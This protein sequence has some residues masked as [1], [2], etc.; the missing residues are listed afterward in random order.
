VAGVEETARERGALAEAGIGGARASTRQRLA[1]EWHGDT[2]VAFV[3]LGM[4]KLGG[5]ELNY[6]SDVDLVYVYERDGEHA[7]GRTVREF[8]VRV[9]EEVT[10]ALAEVTGEGFCF[11]VDLRLRP[12]GG[13]GPLAISLPALLSYYETFGPI[14]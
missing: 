5:T 2:P 9:A 4:G 13:E 8:F 11:R 3:V 7:S 10:R 6:S 14:C 1:Q 12:G